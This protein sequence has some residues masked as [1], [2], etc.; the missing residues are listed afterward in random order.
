M[1]E[2]TIIHRIHWIL[3]LII[4]LLTGILAGFLVSHSVMLG[5]YFTW[6]IESGNHRVFTDTFAVFREATHANIHYNLFLWAS[7][8]TGTVWT[9][10]CF[11]VKKDRIVALI[12]GLSSFWVGSVFFASGFAEAEAAVATGMASEAVR[13]FFV[14]WNIPMHRSFAVFYTLCFLLLLLAG[15]RGGRS[16]TR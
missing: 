7:F 1:A 5:R 15:C 11:V 14:A 16:D 2:G 10:L 13:Q 4:T 6:L 3:W 12:A 9:I 8:L